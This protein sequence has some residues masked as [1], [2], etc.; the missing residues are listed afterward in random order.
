MPLKDKTVAVIGAGSMGEALIRG[1]AKSG[2]VP[3]NRLI[4]A[5]IRRERLAMV[6]RDTGARVSSDNAH[7]VE[8]ADVV[9]LA[10]K[11]QQMNE[12]LESIRGGLTP[13]KLVISIAA[14]VPTARIEAVLGGAVRVVRA[15]PN[16]AAQV[17]EGAAAIC[18]G[19]YAAEADL[20]VAEA[21]LEGV[22]LVVRVQESQ[23]DAVTALSGTGPAYL[24]LLVEAMARAGVE[25]GLAEDLARKLSVQTVVGAARLLAE[26]GEDPAALRRRV[27][28]PGGTTQAAV[29][30]LKDGGFVELM[31]EA[32][33]AAAIRSWELSGS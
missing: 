3:A 23:M 14:G 33:K 28:S 18:R 16:M 11:P 25:A 2:S 24:F 13:D 19:S 27:T 21:I 20:A 5:D 4:A 22:G 12:T 9:L 6:A 1:L 7:A 31:S 17:G 29:R 15:M 8:E 30:V 32:V 10:V 26:T